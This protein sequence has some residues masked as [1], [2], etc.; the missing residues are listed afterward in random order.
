MQENA[1]E[2]KNRALET[3]DIVDDIERVRVKAHQMGR[4]NNGF[5]HSLGIVLDEL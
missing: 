4:I 3:F 5:V 2:R 1:N